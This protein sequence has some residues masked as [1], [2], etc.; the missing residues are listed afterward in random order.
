MSNNKQQPS[1]KEPSVQDMLKGAGARKRRSGWWGWLFFLLLLGA[2]GY[3][4]WYY[5]LQQQ[6]VAATPD[7]VTE[8]VR[9]G[10]LSTSVTATGNLQPLNQVDIGTELSGTV[11]AVLVEQN[12]RVSKGQELAS[13]NIEQLED[14]ITKAKAT[15]ITAKAKVSQAE[16]QLVQAQ[17]K[18]KQA[19]VNV[20]QAVASAEQAATNARQSMANV[21]Q[22]SNG[23]VQSELSV[24]QSNVSVQQG[25]ANVEQAK[26]QL[27]QAKATTLDARLKLNSLQQLYKESGGKLPAKVDLDAATTNWKKALAAESAAQASLNSAK[28]GLASTRTSVEVAKT[29]FNS[30][31]TS[32]T[33]A[34]LGAE[35]AKI[36]AASAKANIASVKAG[37]EAANADEVSA[38]ANLEAAKAGVMDAEANLRSAET[39]LTKATIRSPIDGVVLTRSV[40]VGQTVASSLSAPTLFTLAED[41]AKMEL[42]VGVDEAD[43]GQVKDGQQAEFTVDAW[44]GRKFPARISRVSLGST[45]S[46][47]VVTYQTVLTVDNQD[48]SLRPG[49]TATASI[50]TNERQNVLLVPSAALRFN[51]PRPDGASGG[52]WRSRAG[53][54]EGGTPGAAP[55]GAPPAQNESFLSKLM[56]RPPMRSRPQ[57]G[58]RSGGQ[59]GR[60]G[61][62]QRDPSQGRVWILEDGKPKRIRVTVGI[63]DGKSTEISSDEL[64]EGMEVITESKVVTP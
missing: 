1:G 47:N 18:V 48:L 51:P 10:N 13:L 62:R 58:N 27:E 9:T 23:V 57:P 52:D 7:Y 56:P 63:S 40:E 50:V 17:S 12:A 46:D 22:S 6:Q 36:S 31:K 16:A 60:S 33:A 14:A 26:A 11:K 64:K 42:R 43:V 45:L 8:A 41:L 28:A 29:S 54:A 34:K 49:M 15:L 25:L 30:S 59:D 24:R 39:N 37:V 4:G 55:G 2:A 38:R 44:P 19:N 35:A 61:G 3:G 20:Q 53:G 5:Y 21:S 32:V